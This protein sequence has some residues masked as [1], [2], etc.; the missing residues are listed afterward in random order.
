MTSLL[1][2]FNSVSFTR[3]KR[4]NVAGWIRVE[5][6]MVASS[7]LVYF[8]LILTPTLYTFKR[9]IFSSQS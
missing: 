8:D 1:W 3:F 4:G 7:P 9:R 2:L 5:K 6:I